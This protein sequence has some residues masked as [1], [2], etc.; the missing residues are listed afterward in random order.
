[1]AWTLR[2]IRDKLQR[3]QRAAERGEW[4][5]A[6]EQLL[7]AGDARTEVSR[8]VGGWQAVVIIRGGG[9]ALA[10]RVRLDEGAALK[11]AYKET[12][13]YLFDDW[14]LFRQR[15]AIHYRLVIGAQAARRESERAREGER[16]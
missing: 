7:Q 15:L 14:R 12:Y 13:G 10:G 11:E 6:A 1:M 8:V 16:E 9:Q 5:E 4:R 3:A 2:S